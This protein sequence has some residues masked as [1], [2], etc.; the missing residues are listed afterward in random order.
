MCGA[1]TDAERETLAGRTGKP[2]AIDPLQ[3][4][5]WDSLLA[6]H[7]ESSFFH[8]SA[9]ARVLHDTYGHQPAYFCRF[10]AG[11]LAELL[12]VMEVS[13]RW[14]GRRGVSLPFTDFCAP[15]G[16]GE[17][18]SHALYDAVLAYGRGRGWR[19]L[20]CRGAIPGRREA[21]PSLAFYGHLIDLEAG[22]D[23]L[24]S[25]LD[26]AVRRGIRKAR[27]VRLQVE[28]GGDL[29]SVRT[30]YALHCR[31]RSRHALPPQPFRF[32]ENIARHVLDRGQGGVFIARAGLTPVAAALFFHHGRQ[33][34][35]KFGASDHAFQSLRPNNLVMW[36]A[37]RRYAGEG[38]TGLH[39]GRTSLANEGLRRFK[40][41]FGA[42]EHRIEY[43]KYDFSRREFVVD[44]D[45][46]KGWF[47][48]VF[49]CLPLPLLR[50]AGQALYRHLS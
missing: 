29:E 21:P 9:W 26:G 4:P 46:A 20:E 16:S 44:T 2:V 49:R 39:L 11:Q 41:G 36:E 17:G 24:F 5:A 28:F 35:Y 8:R 18:D 15:L 27:E 34:L 22:P 7:P 31:T 10:A 13:S 40:L 3:Y 6:P 38:F 19:Y 37:M 33:A 42:T 23:A 50:L 47:N 32:F 14:T 30:F 12:P 45:R 1:V 43:S 25:G 48:G